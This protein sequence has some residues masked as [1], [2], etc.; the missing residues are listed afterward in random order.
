M[1]K[2]KNLTLFEES[3]N[4]GYDQATIDILDILS[5][6]YPK[7]K[8]TYEEIINELLSSFNTKKEKKNE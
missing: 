5:K 3:Y 4:E 1:I 8:K 7:K 2:K 6:K